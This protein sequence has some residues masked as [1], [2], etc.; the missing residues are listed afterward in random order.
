M[1]G[2]KIV[3]KKVALALVD[4]ASRIKMYGLKYRPAKSAENPWNEEK[5]VII[6]KC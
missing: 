5:Q 2:Q 4:E 6:L 3:W 1:V